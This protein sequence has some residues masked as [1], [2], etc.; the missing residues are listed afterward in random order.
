M[1]AYPVDIDIYSVPS[2]KGVW[3]V[4]RKENKLSW[5]YF[6]RGRLEIRRGK[7]IVFA[8]T[9]CYLF[10]ELLKKL[11]DIYNLGDINL[12]GVI[13]FAVQRYEGGIKQ[14]KIQLEYTW[15]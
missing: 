6:P 4:L 3:E 15:R 7:A 12:K 8:N 14:I 9:E 2:H 10:P 5:N 1:I 13:C 11:H